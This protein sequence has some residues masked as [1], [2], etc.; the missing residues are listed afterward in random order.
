[1]NH[2]SEE[3]LIAYQLRESG[4]E[5]E[6]RKHL[7]SCLVC[8]A[9]S[10]AIAETLRV[11]SAETV[12]AVDVERSWQRVRGNLTLLEREPRRRFGFLRAGWF[13]GA[14]GL[15]V[16]ALLVLAVM[17]GVQ[18]RRG[19]VPR[20]NY[21][22]NGHGPL[23]TRPV[24]TAIANHLDAAERLLT[25]VNHASGPLDEATRSQAH[26]LLLKNAVYVS[27]A[28]EHGDVAEAAVLDNL[29]RV[30][31]SIDHSAETEHKTLQLRLEMNTDG[32]LLDIRILRQ[33]DQ[34]GQ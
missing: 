24:D 1:M 4:E 12:P 25:E 8:A 2:F 20:P 32:L 17:L 16:T 27:S 34:V 21:A 30:L 22:I 7:E 18:V 15:A 26:E 23:T 3:E 33:N 6:I 9:M 28:H 13:W 14:A 5:R 19:V 29:G 31:T 10:D 11:F